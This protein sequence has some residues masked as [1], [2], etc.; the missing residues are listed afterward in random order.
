MTYIAQLHKHLTEPYKN[1]QKN[2]V[3]PY[4]INN[5]IY[6][7]FLGLLFYFI[8][9]IMAEIMSTCDHFTPNKQFYCTAKNKQT[10]KQKHLVPIT[11]PFFFFFY[12]RVMKIQWWSKVQCCATSEHELH[13]TRVYQEYVLKWPPAQGEQMVYHLTYCTRS[14]HALLNMLIILISIMMIAGCSSLAHTRTHTH[15]HTHKP[16]S[17]VGKDTKQRSTSEEWQVE[18]IATGNRGR[19]ANDNVEYDWGRF[20]GFLHMAFCMERQI[21]PAPTQCYD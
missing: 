7:D 13:Q 14:T 10:N 16:K 5:K 2:I 15:T 20:M 18:I 17:D 8:F 19:G 4:Q 6:T 3:I 1:K 21:F 12:F 11:D 9:I